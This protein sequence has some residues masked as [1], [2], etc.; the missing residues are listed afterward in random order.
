MSEKI[1]KLQVNVSTD[2]AL[3]GVDLKNHHVN[4]VLLVKVNRQLFRSK[5]F[6]TG[7]RNGLRKQS[8]NSS[9][10]IGSHDPIFSSLEFFS[11]LF[12]PHRVAIFTMKKITIA[13][14]MKVI[15]DTAKSP[16]PKI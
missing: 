6:R 12:R 9:G 14:M 8:L 13:T 5:A 1:G 4:K 10:I 2:Y 16:I 3:S 11:Y 15:T 7:V